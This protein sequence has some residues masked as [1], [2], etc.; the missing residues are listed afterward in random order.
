MLVEVY[1]LR[2]VKGLGLKG[3]IVSVKKGYAINFLIPKGL[4][5]L[6]TKK[7]KESFLKHKQ[8]IQKQ[9]E[10]KSKM[11]ENIKEFINRK[12]IKKPVVIKVKTS[13]GGKVFG[14]VTSDDVKKVL[15]NRIPQLK[16]FKPSEIIIDM[17]S[18]I[19]YVGKYAFDVKIVAKVEDKQINE[20]I[21]VFVDIVSISKAHLKTTD[22]KQKDK[23]N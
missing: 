22:T 4:A 8:S 18:K 3:D 20:T 15:L 16:I 17:P 14:S 19:E 7:D 1:L 10:Q 6:A 11:L 12:L 9:V 13:S 2:D 21:P 5:R 23:E